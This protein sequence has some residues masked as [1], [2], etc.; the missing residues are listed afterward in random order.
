MAIT[1]ATAQ[2]P[3]ADLEEW[4]LSGP[5]ERLIGWNTGDSLAWTF[6]QN[7]RTTFREDDT[8]QNGNH[9]CRMVT[10]ET[11]F[12]GTFA[13]GVITTGKI[14]FDFGSFTNEVIEGTPYTGRP[15][16]LTGYWWYLPQGNDYAIANCF[17]LDANEDTVG[18]GRLVTT[19][20]HS[21][22]QHFTVPVEYRNTDEPAWLQVTISSGDASQ[23]TEF[24]KLFVDNLTLHGGDV[25]IEDLSGF[26]INVIAYPNP[27]TG[28]ITFGEAF[29]QGLMVEIFTIDGKLLL[30]EKLDRL[31]KQV[32]VSTLEAGTYVYQITDEGRFVSGGKV[33]IAR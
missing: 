6:G 10:V 15:D 21:G 7:H 23:A 14:E 1:T 32:D 18:K 22:W 4:D 19:D 12:A 2:L 31:Q 13:P 26:G 25:G 9:A 8:V 11:S 28:A 29:G 27:A 33:E 5:Y 3:N 17:L 30:T 24:S 20:M 16:S